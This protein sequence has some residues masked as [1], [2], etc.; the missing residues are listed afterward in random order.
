MYN[1]FTDYKTPS[2]GEGP[3][4]TDYLFKLQIDRPDAGLKSCEWNTKYTNLNTHKDELITRFN[5]E[6]ALR[7]IGAETEHRWQMILQNRL[8]EVSEHYDHMYKVFAENNVD[9]LGTG[10]TTT[11]E[12]QRDTESSMDSTNERNADSKYKDT[13]SNSTSTIN[14]PTEQTVNNSDETYSSTGTGKQTDKRTTTKKLHDDVMVRE[15][16]YLVDNYK[17]IDNEFIKE[18]ENCFIGIMIMPD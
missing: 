13:P 12:F 6:Y 4:F 14:N 10:Y 17:S 15:L 7:E 8:D 1:I 18:F 11:D 9:E 5:K 2:N 3:F 16:N